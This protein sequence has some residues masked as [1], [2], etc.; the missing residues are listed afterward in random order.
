MEEQQE[1]GGVGEH[2]H[3][4]AQESSTEGMTPAG[5]PPD[6][7][8]DP[9]Q[10]NLEAVHAQAEPTEDATMMEYR[11]EQNIQEAVENSKEIADQLLKNAI[12]ARKLEEIKTLL[13]C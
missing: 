13:Q 4:E 12:A 3:P 2:L 6:V 8:P 1:V 7:S 9:G 10:V 11:Q 5:E